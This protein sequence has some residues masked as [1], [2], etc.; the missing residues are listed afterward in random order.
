[1]IVVTG[2]CPGD[3]PA[4]VYPDYDGQGLSVIRPLRNKHVEVE[5]VLVAPHRV[6]EKADL[7]THF[8][9]GPRSV[10]DTIPAGVI[11]NWRPEPEVTQWRLRIRNILNM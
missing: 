6:I 7:R 1:M 4:T 3:V 5:A 2:A 11:R 8:V 10:P 9:L